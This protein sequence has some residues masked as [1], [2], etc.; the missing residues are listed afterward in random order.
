MEG[1]RLTASVGLYRDVETDKT[2]EDGQRTLHLK[3]GQRIMIDCV[4]TI[5]N[6]IF[7]NIQANAPHKVTASMDE[8]GFPN[9][10]A[11]DLTR[12]LDS[13]IHYG[14]GPHICLGYDASKLAL[15]TMLKTIGKLE[16]LRR[17]PGPQGEIKKIHVDG[18]YTVYLTEDGSSYFPFPT[19]MKVQWDGELPP[20]PE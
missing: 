7:V 1:S 19:T 5:N 8:E 13:Y 15:T 12:D 9:P 3:K 18:G 11:V 16:N 20:V 14:W 4:S 6:T 2:V 17:A 10:R